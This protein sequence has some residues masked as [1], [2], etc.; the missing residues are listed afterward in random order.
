MTEISCFESRRQFEK[1]VDHIYALVSKR[2]I[3]NWTHRPG[4]DASVVLK[5]SLLT[6]TFNGEQLDVQICDERKYKHSKPALLA[7]KLKGE[8]ASYQWHLCDP[9]TGAEPNPH[10][11]IDW[12]PKKSSAKSLAKFLYSQ[13]LDHIT[14]SRRPTLDYWLFERDDIESDESKGIYQDLAS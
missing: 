8:G 3:T 1:V 2:R 5:R 10:D 9:E 4:C 13:L 12:P 6:L 14:E 7:Y 11:V